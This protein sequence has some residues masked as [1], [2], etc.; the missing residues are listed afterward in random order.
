M[1]N[2]PNGTKADKLQIQQRSSCDVSTTAINEQTGSQFTKSSSL[3]IYYN[4][5]RSIINKS[6]IRT[7]IELSVYKILVFTEHWLSIRDPDSQYFPDKFDVHRFNRD[8]A[9][10]R[11]VAAR[12]SGGVAILIHS[13]LKNRRLHCRQDVQCEYVAVEIKIKPIPLIIY[14]AYMRV[15]DAAIA[16]IHCNNINDLTSKYPSHMIMVIGDFNIDSV[17]WE[18]D[19]T[20][21]Y[22][23][24]TRARIDAS[25]FLQTMQDLSFHQ[26]SNF[27]NYANNV[28]DL[29]YVNEPSDLSVAVDASR[30]IEPVQQDRAHVPYEIT[31]KYSKENTLSGIK[32][33]EVVCF[34]RGNY[35]R[36]R[37]QL[38]GI[39]FQHEINHRDLDSAFDFF[40]CTMQS[41]V[42][43]NVPKTVIKTNENKPKWWSSELQRLKNRRDKLYKRSK[44]EDVNDEYTAASLKFNELAATL[45]KRYIDSVQENINVNPSD[46]W[47][48]AKLQD[49]SP[50]Y[51]SEM[52]YNERIGSTPNE[53]VELFADFFETNYVPDIEQWSFES[54]Y[55]ASADA[56]EINVTL[57]DIE[58]AI[59]SLKWK[60]G[61]GPDEVSPYVIKMCVESITWPIWLLFQK[62]FEAGRIPERLKRARIVPIFKNGDKSGINNYRMI[63]ITSVILKIFERAIK[64]QLSSI[65]EPFISNAQHGFRS[66][67]SITTNLLSL[68]IKAHEA[69]ERSNQ[70]DI[71]YGDFKS[72]F[73]RVC[74]RILISKMG[75]F[76]IG[77][78]TAK[79][80]HAFIDKFKNCVQIGSAKS[81]EYQATSGVPAG[82]TLASPLFS[83]FINDIDEVVVHASILLFADDIK[84]LIEVAEVSD[85]NKLQDDINRIVEWCRVNHLFFNEGKCAV[86]TACR[87]ATFTNAVYKLNDQPIQRKNVIKDLGILLDQRLSFAHHIE[88]ITAQARQMIGY[89]K[90]VSNGRFT[91]KTKK[92]LYLA[93]VRS[94]L[95]FGSVIWSPYQ[96]IYI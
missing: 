5:V 42:Q 10:E 69:F 75:K 64:S 26:M 57:F 88:H 6:N 38:D 61:M 13:R 72:A 92:T 12:R 34:R 18:A 53:I 79:W 7:K 14:A 24:P 55:R 39:N 71:F 25:E 30:I 11:V 59:H 51:P 95:E 76:C 19:E 22:Y 63:A 49:K 44:H 82:C 33:S 1:R 56:K 48:F 78:M 9:N 3:P 66:K 87:K 62:S 36:M 77:P 54:V 20:G 84:A 80:I 32:K 43:N 50:S 74:H 29:V 47:Q 93:Y 16:K 90:R 37:Q 67:R 23:I 91:T 52:H 94:K 89:I 65:I 70:L 27:P 45:E 85:V 68:S 28:L 40:Y 21:T 2:V 31:Y 81:R 35:E 4:N 83:I 58:N 41:L 60:G 15:F 17:K 86:F 96:D 46:F 8:T 73:D